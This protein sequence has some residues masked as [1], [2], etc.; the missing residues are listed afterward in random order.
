MDLGEKEWEGVDWMHLVKDKDLWLGL[1]TMV[2]N[3]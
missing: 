1:V 3:L 2:L